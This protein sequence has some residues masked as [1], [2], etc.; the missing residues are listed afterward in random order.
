MNQFVITIR[1]TK[2]NQSEDLI[3]NPLK[4]ERIR[5]MQGLSV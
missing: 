3:F 5:F 2:L 4:T 1:A